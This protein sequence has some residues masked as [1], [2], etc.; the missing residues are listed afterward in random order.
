MTQDHITGTARRQT[1]T[2]ADGIGL[3]YLSEGSGDPVLLLH[4]FSSAAREWWKT[5]VAQ[6]LAAERRVIAPD[7]R[8]HGESDRPKRPG[9]YGM[10]MLRDIVEL[11]DHESLAAPDVIGFSMGAELALALGV[12]HPDRVR[13]LTLAGSGWSPDGI[14]DEY[15]KWFD[16]LADRSESP[17]ALRT[18]IEGVPEVTDLPSDAVAALPMPL[19]GII[20][21]LDDE[22]PYMERICTVRP[23]FRPQILPG[24]DHIGT[25]RSPEFPA[26]LKAAL[27]RVT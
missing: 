8:G 13:S 15:R 21:E 20:G 10:R 4:G 23:D 16:L 22:R 7:L 19:Q 6:T 1:I 24:L 12:H 18:L 11:L 17:D 27:D 26:L 14:L 9:S 3:S 25:W 5:G 2:T